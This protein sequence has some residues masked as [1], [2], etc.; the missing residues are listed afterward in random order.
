MLEKRV[1]SRC[2]SHVLQM[3]PPSSFTSFCELGKRLLRAAA[4]ADE[5]AEWATAWNAEVEVSFHGGE[6]KLDRLE[7]FELTKA[8]CTLDRHSSPRR[9]SSTTCDACG[10][11]TATFQPSSDPLW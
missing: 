1:R 11:F 6:S 10:R 4:A 8:S 5:S 3:I 7:P 2:Q 9:R